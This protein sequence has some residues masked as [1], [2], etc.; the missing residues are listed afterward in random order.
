MIV[1]N[2]HE[3]AL[4]NAL[5][6]VSDDVHV[7]MRFVNN[8]VMSMFYCVSLNTST[9]SNNRGGYYYFQGST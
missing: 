1:H 4:D 6:D 9:T 3:D 2:A 7:V 5:F 8:W